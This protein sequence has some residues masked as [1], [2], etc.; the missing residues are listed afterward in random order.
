MATERD[1]YEILGVERGASA[2]EIRKAHRKLARKLHP[3]VNKA[4]DAAQ[5]FSEIQEAYDVLSDAQK[6]EAYDRFGHAGVGAGAGPGPRSGRTGGP[7]DGW[8]P[9][10]HSGGSVHVD[11]SEFSSIFED[12]FGGEGPFG[13]ASGHGSRRGGGGAGFRTGPQP[14]RGP[15]LEHAI[16]VSFLTAAL[17]GTEQLRLS[18]PDGESQQIDV[19]I[20]AGVNPGAKLRVRDKGNPGGFGGEP[21]DLILTIQVSP[22][23]WFRREG[24]DLYLDV[25]ITI[26]EAA[27]GTTV[28]VP[29]LKGSAQIKIPP[30]PGGAS[31]GRK[32]RLKGKGIADSKGH[33]GDFHAVVQ[34]VAPPHL[35]EPDLEMLRDLGTRLQNPRE[36]APWADLVNED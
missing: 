10:D 30:A 3:D 22:H 18:S 17:G 6:R 11:P 31:S 29:L 24:L 33:H 20:P 21:G 8:S 4:A 16:T 7:T 9:P 26:A 12:L 23:P 2:E 5:R 36:S 28:K 19:K 32:L 35:S 27:L 25:P 34:I 1:Y 15:D 13:R 14:R